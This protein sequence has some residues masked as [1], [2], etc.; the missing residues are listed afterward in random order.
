MNIATHDARHH[1]PAIIQAF[2]RS[3]AEEY[4]TIPAKACLGLLW[5]YQRFKYD[6][7]F[8]IYITFTHLR[9]FGP[10][11]GFFELET[12][13]PRHLVI[14]AYTQAYIYKFCQCDYPIFVEYQTGK[15]IQRVYVIA[16]C[17]VSIG[18]S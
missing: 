7:L 8:H 9:Y 6:H 3:E 16:L 15:D 2:S 4:V 13:L 12:L 14:M 11:P 10:R 5:I 18:Q 1:R 17:I